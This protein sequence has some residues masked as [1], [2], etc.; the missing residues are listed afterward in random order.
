MDAHLSVI[1]NSRSITGEDKVASFDLIV[2]GKA[3]RHECLIGGFAVY[4]VKLGFVFS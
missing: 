1:L 3:C 2:A 4:E